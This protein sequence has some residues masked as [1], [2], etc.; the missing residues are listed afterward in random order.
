TT[1]PGLP[2]PRRR[3]LLRTAPAVL[4]RHATVSPVSAV[5]TLLDHPPAAGE[6][7][8]ATQWRGSAH[9]RGSLWSTGPLPGYAH[10]TGFPGVD[11][12]I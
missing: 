4:R 5:A 7:G 2:L 8:K 1:R 6:R 9:N 10:L 11:L 3:F 12:L